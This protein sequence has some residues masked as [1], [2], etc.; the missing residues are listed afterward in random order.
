MEDNDYD[1][2]GMPD[3]GT[4]SC[5]GS[6][7]P[8]SMNPYF[9]IFQTKTLRNKI[10][11]IDELH[12]S[13]YNQ[14]LYNKIPMHNFHLDALGETS[15]SSNLEPFYP[16]FFAFLEKCTVLFLY[17]RSYNKTN[18]DELIGE[19]FPDDCITTKLF[20][21]EN[22]ELLYHTWYARSYL[23]NESNDCHD[24]P[25]YNYNRITRIIKSALNKHS[26]EF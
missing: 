7:N 12:V 21:H 24:A 3:G 22:K 1:M 8:A 4:Y 9:N 26:I 23:Y 15:T 13:Q 18:T 14:S 16:F 19:I 20:N 5:R 25:K 2:C 6:G 10:N 11:S 17:G